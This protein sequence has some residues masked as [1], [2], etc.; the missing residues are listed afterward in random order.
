MIENDKLTSKH[1]LEGDNESSLR[2]LKI[3][4]FVGQDQIKANLSIFIS[5][6]VLK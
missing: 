4:D 1:L 2:P 5:F 3:A 6:G